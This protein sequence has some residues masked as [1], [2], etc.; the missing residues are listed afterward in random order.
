MPK[1]SFKVLVTVEICEYEGSKSRM[2]SAVVVWVR[3]SQLSWVMLKST[4]AG[5]TGQPCFSKRATER[6]I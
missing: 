4:G 2:N 6:G 5:M 3:L 1:Y